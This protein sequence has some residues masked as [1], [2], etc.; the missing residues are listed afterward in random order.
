MFNMDI[1]DET[2]RNNHFRKVVH[3]GKNLQIVLMS[4]KPKQTI[5]REIHLDHDQFIRV[6]KGNGRA[7][8]SNEKKDIIQS[9]ELKDDIAIVI[10][11]GTYHE[12]QN[13]GSD[14]L[15]FY[16]IYSPPEHPDGLIQDSVNDELVKVGGKYKNK[17]YECI[18]KICNKN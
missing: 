2:I 3:T 13:T 6:E 11:A 4:L 14:D 1:N 16:T 10:S 9:I 18:S 7:I 17:F 8:I 12:I 15:K 5:P